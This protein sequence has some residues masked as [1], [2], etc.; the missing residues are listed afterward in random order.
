MKRIILCACLL[1]ACPAA[2]EDIAADLSLHEIEVTVGFSGSKLLV[3]GAIKKRA[4]VVVVVEGPPVHAKLWTKR[5][6][7]IFWVN[8]RPVNYDKVPGFY[9]IASSRPLQDIVAPKTAADYE[10]TL[11]AVKLNP[12]ENRGLPEVDNDGL[13]QV[14]KTRKLYQEIPDG[15]RVSKGGLFRADFDLPA[16]L[17]VGNYKANIFLLRN[18]KVFAK[19]EVPLGVNH[20]G[21]EASISHLA[22]ERPFAYAFVALLSALGLGGAASSLFRRRT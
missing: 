9:A 16:A 3:F 2:A 15:V 13:K 7:G 5:R 4:D 18:G 1:F 11:A 14:Q 6:K 12:E 8:D 17:P 21:L 19:Q 10:L 20:V 22:H